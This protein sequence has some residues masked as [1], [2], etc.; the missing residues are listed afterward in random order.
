MSDQD[1]DEL[2]ATYMSQDQWNEFERLYSSLEPRIHPLE[3]KNSRLKA[4]IFYTLA[5]ILLV[6]IAYCFFIILQLALFNLIMLV[7]M[8][9]FWSKLFNISR[10]IIF[11]ILDNDRK[12]AFKQWIR[13]LKELPW[14]K[15]KSIEIQ[16]NEQGRWIEIHLNET[17][18]EKDDGIAEDENEN[19]DD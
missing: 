10:A 11:K 4:L 16:E 1:K 18:D 17:T 9:V 3:K 5:F 6:V 7:V 15:E 8:A 2:K 14:L 19:E 12:K 13:R